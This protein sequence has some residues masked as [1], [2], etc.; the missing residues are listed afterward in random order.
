M[1]ATWS[2]IGG[3]LSLASPE[4]PGS[5]NCTRA[6]WPS[7]LT[8]AWPSGPTGAW[9]LWTLGSL[10]RVLATSPTTAWKSGSVARLEG[11]WMSTLSPVYLGKP[12][13]SRI[14]SA[15]LLSPEVMSALVT[16]WFSTSEERAKSTATKTIQ[17]KTAVFQW[18]ALHR[19]ARALRLRMAA[20]PLVGPARI[21][22]G[23]VETLRPYGWRRWRASG[24]TL[25]PGKGQP[26]NPVRVGPHRIAGVALWCRTW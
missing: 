8:S 23:S 20:A 25:E 16:W 6:A 9:R 13:L 15:T 24:P 1:A 17:P 26:S 4:F 11:C 3:T 19:P 12:A 21:A 14:C 18:A 2:R 22:P 5:W 10:P 7:W